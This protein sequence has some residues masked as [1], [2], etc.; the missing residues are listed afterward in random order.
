MNPRI[1]GAVVFGV[2]L[3]CGSFAYTHFNRAE[4]ESTPTGLVV[5][6][7][8]QPL[9]N[10][11]GSNDKNNNG[12][13]DWQEALRTEEPIKLDSI[14]T[15]T[16]EAPTTVTGQFAVDFFQQIVQ[17]KKFGEFGDTPEELIA[18]ANSDLVRDAQ[19]DTLFSRGDIIILPNTTPELARTYA[20]EIADITIRNGIPADTPNEVLILERAIQ[21]SNPEVLNEL[22]VIID[23]Y[24]GMVIEMKRTPV[25]NELVNE[26]LDLLNVYQI[27]LTNVEAMKLAFED[28]L[29]TL[30]RLQRYQDD[31]TKLFFAFTGVF[32]AA[33]EAGARFD[34]T[35]ST[36]RVVSFPSSI[37]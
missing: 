7:S 13:P 22:D 11:I 3:V 16:Y 23:S 28:P 1:F 5:A 25:P 34:Q 14:A 37:E 4:I 20:N 17:N 24:Q 8:D 29:Y 26:H 32:D 6:K 18:Q 2:L 35:D 30:L 27:I 19:S 31:A 21:R 33:Y 9:R 10:Y 36:E 12:V 15:S